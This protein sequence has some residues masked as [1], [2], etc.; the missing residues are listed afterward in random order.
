MKQRAGLREKGRGTR[1]LAALAAFG[2]GALC[3][4]SGFLAPFDRAF[5]DLQTRWLERTVDSD[6]TIVDIDAR[7]LHDLGAWPWRRSR[8]AE[9]IEQLQRL[10]ARRL[11][12]DIDFSAP[13]THPEDDQRLASA[14][15]RSA[16][17]VVL[18]TFWQPLSSD[19]GALILSEPLPALRQNVLLGSVNLVPGP[20]GLVREIADLTSLSSRSIPPV[21]KRLRATAVDP[22]GRPLLLDYRIAPQSFRHYSYI[23]ILDGRLKPDLTG[24]T[25]FIGATAIELGDMVA[26]PVHRALPGIVVQAISYESGRRTAIRDVSLNALLPLLFIWAL[27]CSLWLGRLRWSRIPL[28]ASALL[29]LILSSSVC[30]YA[31]AS[32]TFAPS[33][34]LAALFVTLAATLLSSLD[35]EA[36]RSFRA[37]LRL[38]HQDALLRQIVDNS[39]DGILTLDEDGLVR[40]VNPAAARIFRNGSTVMCGRPVR[41]IAPQLQPCL[42]RLSDQCPQLTQA[43]DLIRAD[44]S[45]LATEVAMNR[46]AWE[47][48][49]VVSV[50]IRDVTAQ[51]EREQDLHYHATHDSLTGLPN[52]RF[53]EERLRAVLESGNSPFGL[54]MLDLNGFKQVNDTLGHGTGDHLLV[55]LGRR[56]LRFAADCH[57]V[58]RVGG[59]E[60]ALL[61]TDAQTVSLNAVC[62][63]VK[64]SLE[65]PITIRGIPV[66]LGI[67]TGVSLYPEHGPDGELLLQRADIALYSAKRKHV[68]VEIYDGS[69]DMGSPRLLR[70]LTLLRS[71]LARGELELYFQPKVS[72]RTGIP[73]EVEALCR[74]CSPEFGNVAAGEFIPLIEASDLIRPLTE[75]T[76][77]HALQC[78]LEWRGR[79][80]ELKVA[81][82]LSARNLQDEHLPRWLGELFVSTGTDP[83]WLELEI[84]E[85]AIM[86]DAE[87]ALKTLGGIRRLGVTLSIDDYG[88]GYSSLAYLRKLAVNRLKIDRS[89]VAGLP[90]SE[91]DVLIVKST[92][93]LAHGLGL[94]VI[95]EGIETHGQYAKLQKLGCD[96]GQGYL[97]ARPMPHEALMQWYAHQREST[98][99]TAIGR[100]RRI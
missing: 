41:E 69:L 61:L 58:A 17:V 57:C 39:M 52:R 53:L 42:E 9:V 16:G 91:H 87:R 71:A 2:I 68:P 20:D 82:N 64:A 98:N 21:W 73:N 24:K 75:W 79:G 86:T 27:V 78:C 37:L 83:S 8:H 55:E 44:G 11:F 34:F 31:S 47:D 56:L 15:I 89:F 10:G 95:A 33:T 50:S 45:E 6:V 48:T 36:W 54:L 97:I 92:I 96:Y 26:V 65:A 1:V 100:V 77:R 25:V 5:L 85:S 49:F 35:V 93:D 72:L 63:Q 70:M 22:D 94:E 59:D 51:R 81:V 29:A 32:L 12:V 18:P 60:F 46:L 14:L 7:S 13:S 76:L 30:L 99:A 80:F 38:R 19:G 28:A 74:W 84:T 88:T 40:E 62:A 23:D 67:S 43:I 90:D 66:S 3:S 4:I